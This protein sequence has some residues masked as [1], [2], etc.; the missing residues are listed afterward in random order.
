V[1]VKQTTANSANCKQQQTANNS[2]PSKLASSANSA[3][4]KLGNQKWKGT[5]LSLAALK[6]FSEKR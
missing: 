4:G 3:N 5:S 6:S 2:K 1:Q